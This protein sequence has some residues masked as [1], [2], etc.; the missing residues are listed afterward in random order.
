[1][2]PSSV[3]RALQ[4]SR[5]HDHQIRRHDIAADSDVAGQAENEVSLVFCCEAAKVLWFVRGYNTL[6]DMMRMG[7]ALA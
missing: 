5:R 6:Q 3:T 4:F 1:M 7:Y 2:T